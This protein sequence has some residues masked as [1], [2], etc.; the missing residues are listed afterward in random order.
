MIDELLPY[1][2][3]ELAFFRRM[4]GRF[5]ESNPKIAARLNLGAD[6]S[7]DPHVERLIE[8]FAFLTARI[9]HKLDDDFP[10]VTDALLQSLYPHYLAPVPSMAIVKA[11]FNPSQG[12]LTGGYTFPKG[13]EIQTEPILG[14]PCRFRTCSDTPMWPVEVEQAEIASRPLPAPATPR[15]ADAVAVLRLRLRCLSKEV[16]FDQIEAESLRF[17]LRGLP[18]YVY[19]LYELLFNN[20]LEIAVAATPDDEPALLPADSIRPVGFSRDEGLLP[21]SARSPLA[22]RLL[23]EYFVFPEKFL[24]FELANLREAARHVR[25]P[26]LEI[27]VYLNQTSRDLERNVDAETFQLGCTPVVNLFRQ[28]AEPIRLTETVNE[29]R[30]VPDARRPRSMEVYTVD[31]VAATSSHGDE[32]EYRPFFSVRHDVDPDE[33]AAYWFPVRR[34]GASPASEPDY[35]TEIDLM[36]VDVENRP[37]SLQGWVLDV[38]TTCLNRDLPSRLPFGGDQP[39]LKLT[40]GAGPVQ[41]VTCLTPFT[42]TRRPPRREG[43][44]WRLISHFSLG[45]LSLVDG[46]RGAESLKEILRLYDFANSKQ[47]QDMI[48]SILSVSSRRVAGRVTGER[49]SG[50]CRGVE[51]QVEFRSESFAEKGTYLFARV[52]ERF[53]SLACSIN[54]FT[55]LVAGIRG[56]EGRLFESTPR[57]GEKVLI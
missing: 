26:V 36:L 44:M 50:I 41:K 10:E 54:S 9:R 17:F 5:A 48:D 24:F 8:A 47:T 22:Y 35:G 46:A 30:V 12:K 42:P 2:N 19:P 23:T 55:K 43:A 21:Y 49:H 57:S 53:L 4:A 13:S 6:S 11:V 16:T 1:Y 34:P 28:R 52:L 27:Y 25:H 7:H 37:A 29:Y 3:R 15:S 32:I 20:V 45:H 18:H 39:R 33:Q 40:A 38:E 51:V 14:E 31:S 56:R